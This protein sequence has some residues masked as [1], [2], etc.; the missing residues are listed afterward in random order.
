MKYKYLYETNAL[1]EGILTEA[2]EVSFYLNGDGM[3]NVHPGVDTE[4]QSG[5]KYYFKMDDRE[6]KK[7]LKDKEL[8]LKGKKILD[9][10]DDYEYGSVA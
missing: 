5:D 8:Y 7:F 6:F 9:Q 10:E 3:T 2:K 1:V 4:K